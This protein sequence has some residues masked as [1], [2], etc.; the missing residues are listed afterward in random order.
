VFAHGEIPVR[1][2]LSALVP[3][4]LVRLPILSLTLTA[5]PLGAVVRGAEWPDDLPK[6]D[7]ALAAR[8]P[9]YRAM[10]DAVRRRHGYR[11]RTTEEF[12]LGN[13]TSDA[14]GLVI[15]LNA[16]L[17]TERR[18][19]ILIWEMANAFQRDRFA[20]LSRRARTGEIDSPREY[21]LRMEV[22][23]HGSHQLHRDV[24]EDLER[25]GVRTSTDFLYVV[26]GTARTLAEYRI[27]SAHDYLEHNAKSGHTKHYED[28]YWRTTGRKPPP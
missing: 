19:T 10:A 21:G 16:R 12:P 9:K 5:P 14:Q 11:L 20:E 2:I 13:V 27:P 3:S 4:L 26:S 15:E 18:P 7:A 24:L 6:L 22:V 17:P 25:A 8:S 1:N 28:W 23:E